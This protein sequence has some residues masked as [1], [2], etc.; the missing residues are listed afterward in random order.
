M[1]YCS[2]SLVQ[3]QSSSAESDFRWGTCWWRLQIWNRMLPP[4]R[5][6][7]IKG[8]YLFWAEC[9]QFWLEVW[10]LLS[11]QLLENLQNVYAWLLNLSPPPTFFLC[12]CSLVLLFWCVFRF[13]FKFSC[14][15]KE[16]VSVDYFYFFWELFLLGFSKL[17][18]SFELIGGSCC[19]S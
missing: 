2:V 5:Q 8:F 16:W 14:D 9:C 3:P 11:T 18:N 12:V 17:P 10:R 15:W 1:S 6:T 4:L 13:I 19:T 7:L